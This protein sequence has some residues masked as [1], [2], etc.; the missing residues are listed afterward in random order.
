[1]TFPSR[2]LYGGGLRDEAVPV[3]LANYPPVITCFRCF[4]G[5]P[6]SERSTAAAEAS[7][8][9]RKQKPSRVRERPTGRGMQHGGG[10]RG[11]GRRWLREKFG[12][13]ARVR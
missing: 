3:R 13:E 11:W 10:R 8:M 12:L 5:A 4:L 7:R 9:A 6:G 1:M 2:M